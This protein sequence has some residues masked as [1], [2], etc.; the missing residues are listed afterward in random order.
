MGLGVSVGPHPK[1][2]DRDQAL[3]FEPV[4]GHPGLGGQRP[5]Q[6]PVP[7][8]THCG[9]DRLA[10]LRAQSQPV[11]PLGANL[12]PLFPVA[13]ADP[14]SPP[15]VQFRDGSIGVRDPKVPHPAAHRLL[16]LLEPVFHRDPPR[17]APSNAAGDA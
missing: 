7:L 5:G 11:A 17:N 1:V 15:A 12:A 14:S 9:Q 4:V 6:V 13:P 8:T 16:E 10:K 2:P 3:A